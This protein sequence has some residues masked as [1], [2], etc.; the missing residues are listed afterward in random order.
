MNTDDPIH[1][2]GWNWWNKTVTKHPHI[3]I[4]HEV[5]SVPKGRWETIYA[6]SHPTGLGATSFKTMAKGEE[7][8]ELW[9]RPLVD[10]T[11]GLLRTS[12]GRMSQ[13]NATEHDAY[14]DSYEAMDVY[15]QGAS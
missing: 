15:D 10:A 4:W 5:Y 6:N 14:S 11:R 13:S 12:K 1:R 8:K 3:S 7:G 9:T 2:E